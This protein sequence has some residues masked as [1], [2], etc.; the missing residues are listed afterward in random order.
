MLCKLSNIK[1]Q[2]LQS[3]YHFKCF[4][5]Q[6]IPASFFWF[7]KCNGS[8]H[9]SLGFGKMKEGPFLQINITKVKSCLNLEG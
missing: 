9:S 5:K 7:V 8:L 6:N 4:V 1:P 3:L 2:S